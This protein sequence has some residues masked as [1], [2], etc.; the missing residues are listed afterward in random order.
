MGATADTIW[1]VPAYLPYLQPPLT[2]EDVADAERAIGYRLPAEFVAL[3]R[4]QN[5]GYIRFSLPD[6]PHDSIAG[7]GPYYPSLTGFTDWDEVQEHVS[8]PLAGLIPFDGD[9]HW[10]LCLDYRRDSARPC[11]TYAD[12]ELDRES[13]VAG[14]FAE[15][16]AVLRIEVED[17]WVLEAVPDIEGVKATL[18]AALATTFDLPDTWAHGYPTHRAALPTR[19]QYPE[20]LWLTPNVV[21]RGFVRNDDPRFHELHASL[22][23]YAPRYPE[24]LPNSYILGA[25]DDSRSKVLQ[26]C[27]QHGIALRPLRE[28]MDDT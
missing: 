4:K 14:S 5:G 18:A 9:G 10:H 19:G 25:T 26:A 11:V 13:P 8:F 21:P 16:L 12:I 27:L 7:I 2:D 3:L 20:C 23:G 1:R 28:C 17:K 24:L 6:S 22:P 15:Y